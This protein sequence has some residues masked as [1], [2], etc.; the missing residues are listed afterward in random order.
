MKWRH[1]QLGEVSEMQPEEQEVKGWK[2]LY[3][4]LERWDQLFDTAIEKLH[5]Q[6][7]A[8]GCREWR[9]RLK[10]MRHPRLARACRGRLHRHHDEFWRAAYAEALM[11]PESRI[12]K[13]RF[14]EG[15]PTVLASPRGVWLVLTPD[16]GRVFN[17]FRPHPPGQGVNWEEHD[18]AAQ[19]YRRFMQNTGTAMSDRSQ[20]L[21]RVVTRPVDAWHLA[22][23]VGSA[24][25]DPQPVEADALRDAMTR[26]RG[27]SESVRRAALPT[28]EDLLDALEGALD[29]SS[30]DLEDATTA[31]LS[32]ENALVAYELLLGEAAAKQLHLVVEGLVAW[33]PE[34]WLGLETAVAARREETVGV[35]QAW[36]ETVDEV[37]AAILVSQAETVHSSVSTLADRLTTP[38]W[39]ESW[40]ERMSAVPHVLVKP[41]RMG[42]Q[43]HAASLGVA[44]EPWDVRS[45]GL[46][47]GV[48]L[49]IVDADSPEGENV[50][51]DVEDG[52]AIWLLEKPGQE[53]YV[54]RIE[55]IPSAVDLAT[56]LSQVGKTPGA[57]VFVSW[58]SR[59]S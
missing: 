4:P 40:A 50:T 24:L 16:G 29:E 11:S 9:R 42:V 51:G 45:S 54:V 6:A 27:L 58:I 23:V 21:Q 57:Q 2:H 8:N 37:L 28:Q 36:W 52:G 26:L 32:V 5:S 55:G 38:P 53:A 59:P 41:L 14:W 17:A 15:N 43:T 18:F 48:Q 44:E 33:A 10:G 30:E 49:F 25:A 22:L 35:A 13:D 3:D 19:A 31:V 46:P 12:G 34:S 20:Q 1:P 47:H 39:W 56:A 7:R